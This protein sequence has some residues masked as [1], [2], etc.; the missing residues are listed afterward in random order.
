MNVPGEQFIGSNG[1]YRLPEFYRTGSG[2]NR[3]EHHIRIHPFEGQLVIPLLIVIRMGQVIVMVSKV[4][5]KGDEVIQL[6]VFIKMLYQHGEL[7]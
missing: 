3:T 5:G 1:D 7:G 2:D 4:F 6:P